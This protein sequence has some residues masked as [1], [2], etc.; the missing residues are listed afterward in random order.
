[1][2]T[3]RTG[4]AVLAASFL[5]AAPAAAFHQ[6]AQTLVAAIAQNPRY[7]DGPTASRLVEDLREDDVSEEM[8]EQALQAVRGIN[9]HGHVAEEGDNGEIGGVVRARIAEGL[10]GRRLAAAIH[11]EV[12]A[13][14]RRAGRSGHDEGH[15]GHPH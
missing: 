13:R 14:A 3:I 8:I 11:D 6:Y 9:R 4:G 15:H 1:M 2:R 5:A 7:M 10:R 12:Y